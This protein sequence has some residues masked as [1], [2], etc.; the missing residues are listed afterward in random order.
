MRIASTSQK[1]PVQG[2]KFRLEDNVA[3]RRVWTRAHGRYQRDSAALR[4]RRPLTVRSPGPIISFTFDDFPRS[5]LHQGGAIL[6]R[7]GLAGTYYASFGL[8]GTTG[9]S[10]P[11]FAAEDLLRLF[12]DGHELGCHTFDHCHSWDTDPQTFERSIVDNAVAL[13]RLIPDASF[14]TFSYPKSP[15]RPPIKRAASAQFL[16]CRGGGQTYNSGTIDL[17]YLRAYFLEKGPENPGGI[18]RLIDENRRSRGW[19]IFATHDVCDDP[20]PFGCT[21]AFFEEIVDYSIRSG[22]QIL[23]VVR[24]CDALRA[25]STKT[26]PRSTE[27]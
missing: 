21:P 4:F 3:F 19:L 10:G 1:V 13:K 23:P 16:C 2:L 27:R 7:A 25:S 11:V 5:A 26:S 9:P 22:A 8:M 18:R 17:A 14:R 15:P 24:A 6:T 20:S 12:S